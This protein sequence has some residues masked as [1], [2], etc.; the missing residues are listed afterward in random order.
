MTDPNDVK[1]EVIRKALIKHREDCP[2]EK[3]KDQWLDAR[4][5]KVAG[6]IIGILSPLFVWIVVS[7]FTLQGEVALIKQKQDVISE[8]N[9]ELKEIRKEINQIKVDIA[10]MKRNP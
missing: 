3:D 9:T 2:Y 8:I 5:L 1:T 4:F 7:I 6:V 10:Y